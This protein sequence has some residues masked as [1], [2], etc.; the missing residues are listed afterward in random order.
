LPGKIKFVRIHAAFLFAP[1]FRGFLFG[2]L[3][4]DMMHYST[5]HIPMPWK[6]YKW[7]KFNHMAHHYKT[8]DRRFGVSSGLWDI[9]FR[10]KPTP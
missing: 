9:V 2:Y 5:H 7:L 4:Y 10:T 1:T 3:F 6:W 8:P